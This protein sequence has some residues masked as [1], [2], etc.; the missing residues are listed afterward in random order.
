MTFFYRVS[1]I[2][3]EN[4]FF[5]PVP[6]VVMTTLREKNMSFGTEKRNKIHGTFLYHVKNNIVSGSAKTY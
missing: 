2:E 3:K 4:M 6:I 5:L 1:K